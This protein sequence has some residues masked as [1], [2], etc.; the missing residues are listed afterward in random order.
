M[1]S[2]DN[3]DAVVKFKDQSIRLMSNGKL[4]LRDWQ[5]NS[6]SCKGGLS[7]EIS[8][9]SLIW[10][11]TGDT[12]ACDIDKGNIFDGPIRKREILAVASSNIRPNWIHF[13]VNDMSD[14]VF[15]GILTI[16]SRLG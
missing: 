14:A 16:E 5:S 15:A 9:L 3:E 11:L 8:V 10:H 13:A 4:D 7:K 12:L 1:T 6:E 2:L